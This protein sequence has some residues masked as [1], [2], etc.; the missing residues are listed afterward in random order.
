M[1]S[2]LKKN[3]CSHFENEEVNHIKGKGGT[4]QIEKLVYREDLRKKGAYRR[5]PVWLSTA[6]EE[7][8]KREVVEVGRATQLEASYVREG[9]G[10]L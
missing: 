6:P 7:S 8:T 2:Y 4:F 5:G 3:L 1:I 9:F 10:L